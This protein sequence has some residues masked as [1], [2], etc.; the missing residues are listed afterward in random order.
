[1]G[2][3]DCNQKSITMQTKENIE[4][5]IE[6]YDAYQR[7]KVDKV[8]AALAT[9]GRYKLFHGGAIVTLNPEYGYTITA[10]AKY[11]LETILRKCPL[12]LRAEFDKN[13]VT[14]DKERLDLILR[15]HFLFI[16]DNPKKEPIIDLQKFRVKYLTERLANL[17]GDY[18]TYPTSSGAYSDG[19][20]QYN[21]KKM[22]L[23]I[24]LMDAEQTLKFYLDALL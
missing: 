11:I 13:L 12:V 7:E 10:A 15:E 16:H 19:R 17:S 8:Y 4:C 2:F 6:V 1:M 24:E 21:D 5:I 23:E 18:S 3:I 20:S 9:K 14:C 22:R